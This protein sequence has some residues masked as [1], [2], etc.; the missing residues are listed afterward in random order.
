M[1]DFSPFGQKQR[2]LDI[3]AKMPNRVLNLG[4][5]EWNLDGADV[6]GRALDHR[7]FRPAHGMRDIF[8]LP[9]T[10]GSDPFIDQPG[11]MPRAHRPCVVDPSRKDEIADHSG[12]TFEPACRLA[13]T[14]AVFSN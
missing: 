5:P 8:R 7:R 13:R 11:I 6:A 4:V 14:S 2:V 3:D 9:K 1:L 12:A 10:D